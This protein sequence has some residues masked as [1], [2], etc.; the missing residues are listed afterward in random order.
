MILNGWTQVSAGTSIRLR[1]VFVEFPIQ[2]CGTTS[3]ACWSGADSISM[4][5]DV[6][7]KAEVYS[8]DTWKLFHTCAHLYTHTC[9]RSILHMHTHTHTLTRK[10]H[11]KVNP[12]LKPR[13]TAST[14]PLEGNHCTTIVI[15]S[16]WSSIVDEIG[17][18]VATCSWSRKWPWYSTLNISKGAP[19]TTAKPAPWS[20][21]CHGDSLHRFTCLLLWCCRTLAWL[22]CFQFSDKTPVG[23]TCVAMRE[24]EGYSVCSL[25]FFSHYRG[26]VR[27]AQWSTTWGCRKTGGNDVLMS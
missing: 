18:A 3:K 16:K 20:Q 1:R 9:T 12:A 6:P 17:A 10:R 27:K 23:P 19:Y 22:G 8:T 14:G 24:V 15:I 5:G 7:G 25:R 2:F 21:A 4:C 26:V 11:P 13:K